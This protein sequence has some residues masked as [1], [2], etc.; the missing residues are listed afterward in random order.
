MGILDILKPF[1]EGAED[2]WAKYKQGVSKNVEY[3]KKTPSW[4]AQAVVG[5]PAK[6]MMGAGLSVAKS[7]I[8]LATGKKVEGGFTPDTKM[9][10]FFLGT[11]EIKP[12][13]ESITSSWG[14]ASHLTGQEGRITPSAAL[15]GTAGFAG[16]GV[17]DMLPWGKGGKAVVD[18]SLKTSA[19]WLLRARRAEIADGFLNS[20]KFTDLLKKST[21]STERKAMLF[22]G[23]KTKANELAGLVDNSVLDVVRNPSIK[24]KSLVGSVSKHYEDSFNYI[25]KHIPLEHHQNYINQIWQIPARAK[26]WK[27][28]KLP[29]IAEGLKRGYK[30]KYDDI[31]DLISVYDNS[32]FNL[33]ANQKFSK[34]LFSLVDEAGKPLVRSVD[35]A[36]LEW[37]GKKGKN[38]INNPFLQRTFKSSEVTAHPDIFPYV[39]AI[40]ES[41]GPVGASKNVVGLVNAAMKKGRLSMS[42]F[43]HLALTEAAISV[44]GHKYFTKDLPRMYKA[45]RKGEWGVMEDIP[46]TKRAVGDG[47]SVKTPSDFQRT[48]I[49]ESLRSLAMATKDVPVVGKGVAGSRWFLNKWDTTLFDFLQT[50]YKL[51]A[52]E[53]LTEE[54]T[55]FA[56]KKGKDIPIKK[57]GAE[58]AQFVNDTYGGQ[59]WELLGKSDNWVKGMNNMLLSPDWTISTIRQALAPTGLGAGKVFSWANNAETAFLRRKMGQKFWKRALVYYYGGL[60]TLN[61]AMTKKMTGEGRFMWQNPEGNRMNVMIGYDEEGREKYLRLGKQ[62]R[63]VPEFFDEPVTKVGRKIAPLA[64]TAFEQFTGHSV[65]GYPEE[66]SEKYGWS[67]FG[68]RAK[69]VAGKFVPLTLQSQQFGGFAQTK[70]GMTNY[71]ARNLM[72]EAIKGNNE[73]EFNKVFSWALENNLDAD[74]LKSEAVSKYKRENTVEDKKVAKKFLRQLEDLDTNAER[75]TLIKELRGTGELTPRVEELIGELLEKEQDKEEQRAE[76][77]VEYTGK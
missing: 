30:L 18:A 70:A 29:T 49:D 39:N 48:R 64:Q 36:P 52:Y 33:I 26:V 43:H 61:Y 22:L 77:G 60:N 1:E 72:V 21:T 27:Q 4:I 15:L 51:Y 58:V 12:W 62:F 9:S 40:F 11:D 42:L 25:N 37:L 67:S 66:W 76:H 55:K 2:V 44:R 16:L 17:V 50:S 74:K 5:A 53:G 63:E 20:K 38:K 46:L 45:I 24:L 28:R 69:N 13:N 59:A 14:T 8:E 6:F 68:S 23:Q 71:R 47:V 35:D 34:S 7:G 3:A 57:I 31:T 41:G 65:G 54:M 10:Q 75:M 32:K 73:E 19:K 56:I